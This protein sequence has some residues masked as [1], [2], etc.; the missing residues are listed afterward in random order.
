MSALSPSFGVA[1]RPSVS[2][3]IFG[4][5]TTSFETP[6]TTELANRPDGGGGLNGELRPQKVSSVEFGWRGRLLSWVDFELAAYRANARDELIPFEALASGRTYFRNAGS[7]VHQGVEVSASVGGRDFS[8]R[9][10]LNVNDFHF[11]EFGVAG[12]V[13]DGNE[14]P[15]ATPRRG[16]LEANLMSGQWSFT[17]RGVAKSR[18]AVN[19]ANSEFSPGY[20]LVHLRAQSQGIVVNDLSLGINLGVNNVFDADYNSSVAVNAFGRRYFEPGPGRTIFFG[21]SVGNR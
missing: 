21:I 6:T 4:S 13:F 19:D 5:F 1:Y 9:G 3:E 16:E 2:Q 20:G 15:G 17:L 8:I 18:V 11:E 14:I 10:I 12:N 7:A